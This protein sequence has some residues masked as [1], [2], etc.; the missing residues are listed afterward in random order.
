[1][2][3]AYLQGKCPQLVQEVAAQN[4]QVVAIGADAISKALRE[5]NVQWHDKVSIIIKMSLLQLSYSSWTGG[6][7][8]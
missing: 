2:H 5:Q 1:M 4:A 6:F 8:H 7:W 3:Y